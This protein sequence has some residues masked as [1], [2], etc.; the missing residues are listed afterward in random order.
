[1]FFVPSKVSNSMLASY[2]SNFEFD[3]DDEKFLK[4]KL[5]VRDSISIREYFRSFF[6]KRCKKLFF[7]SFLS[8]FNPYEVMFC[9]KDI[10]TRSSFNF[11]DFSTRFMFYENF[12]VVNNK[13]DDFDSLQKFLNSIVSDVQE[14]EKGGIE[15]EFR[16]ARNGMVISFFLVLSVLSSIVW[17]TIYGNVVME[18]FSIS[19]YFVM[20]ILCLV[21]KPKLDMELSR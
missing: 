17:S 15:S 13:L 8:M 21:V 2:S 9:R 7:S 20:T 10:F 14:I 12:D 19:F 6:A 4:E 1:M 11:F 3:L 18:I 16:C 5:L